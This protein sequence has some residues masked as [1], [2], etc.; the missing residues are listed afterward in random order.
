ML[1][2]AALNPIHSTSLVE[3]TLVP[4]HGAVLNHSPLPTFPAKAVFG[5]L[6]GNAI[7]NQVG[8]A[9]NV[10]V[11][12]LLV[13]TTQCSTSHLGAAIAVS[14]EAA[15]VQLLLAW[16]SASSPP[17]LSG[18]RARPHQLTRGSLQGTLGG[19]GC[20]AMKIGA[21]LT[22]PAGSTGRLFWT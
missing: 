17:K 8:A 19:T 18:V 5:R 20:A 22:T 11:K 6:L 14:F 4:I 13:D 1:V 12:T 7:H 3:M 21:M 10:P 16:H 15:F 2:K 9:S